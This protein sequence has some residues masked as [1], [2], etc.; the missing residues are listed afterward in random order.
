MNMTRTLHVAAAQIHSGGLIED[1]LQR[2]ERQ[3]TAASAVGAE[4]ILFAEGAL[5]GYDYDM[6]PESV[7]AVAEPADSPHCRRLLEMA[8]R[9]RIAI[10]IGFFERS[11]EAIHNSIL[12][13]R[14][15]GTHKTARK[16]I[17]TE[18]EIRARLTPSPRE[19]TIVE[20]NG[21]RCASIVCADGGID[22]LRDELRAQ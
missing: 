5:H 11:G 10:L 8:Q 18:G 21:V 14:P 17:L 13:A 16:H 4:V 19:R 22:G 2:V 7:R 3:V 6:T 9:H 12:V 1:I 20:F 15:D